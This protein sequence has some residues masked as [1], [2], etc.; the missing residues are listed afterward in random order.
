MKKVVI[1]GGGFAGISA[2]EALRDYRFDLDVTLI[3][4]KPT[5]D[6]LPLLPD[7]IGRGINP[8]NL[9]YRIE[10]VAQILRFKFINEQVTAIDLQKQDV[11]MSSKS[12]F[13]DYLLIASGSETNFYGNDNIRNNA[14]KLD[15]ASDAAN[16]M[17]LLKKSDFDNFIV[18]GGGY[19]GIE[20]ATNL[21]VFLNKRKKKGVVTIVERQPTILGPLPQWMKDYVWANLD[22]LGIQVL[23]N[24][25]IEGIDNHSIHRVGGK[26][27]DNGLLIW[28]AGVKTAP[29][30]QN[31]PVEKNPQ[32][33][34]KVDEYLRMNDSCFVAGDAANFSHKSGYLRMAVQF[35][36]MQGYCAAG[37]I[38]RDIE[39]LSLKAYRP[40]DLGY[41]IPMAN[42]ASCGTVLGADLKGRLPTMLHFLMCI[43]RSHGTRNKVGILADLLNPAS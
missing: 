19:T 42:N 38:I 18:C 20:V 14:C 4:R 29:F 24:S 9:A 6:F 2:A 3:D 13:Y 16:L 34:I 25:G 7:C 17:Q 11:V 12:L 41:I 1:I 31:L 22:K 35:S 30:I 37:N 40:Q 28:A 5:F 15:D 23:T 26:R 21:K 32:G 43:F 39:G 27:F 8:D 10:E 33:R 36:I